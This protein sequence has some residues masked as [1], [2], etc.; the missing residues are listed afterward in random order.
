L[1]AL[2]HD[3]I[4]ERAP[5]DDAIGEPRHRANVIGCRNAE[6]Y[7]ERLHGVRPQALDGAGD[8]GHIGLT[9]RA[10]HAQP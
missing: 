10:G 3:R 9:A 8:P 1:S 6:A 2:A 5:D 4:D 7:R